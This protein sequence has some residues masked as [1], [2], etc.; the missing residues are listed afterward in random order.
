M[1]HL[2][3]RE[4][5]GLIT[6]TPVVRMALLAVLLSVVSCDGS[7]DLAKTPTPAI[8]PTGASGDECAKPPSLPSPPITTGTR[9]LLTGPS[10]GATAIL[11][12]SEETPCPGHPYAVGSARLTLEPAESQICYEFVIYGL[13]GAEGRDKAVTADVHRG[14][15][16]A[17]G[18]VVVDLLVPF[19]SEPFFP[20]GCR[21]TDSNVI[22]QIAAE[23][24]AFYIEVHSRAYPNGAVRGQL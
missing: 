8:T 5:A 17:S 13:D 24:S 22:S 12:G 14:A 15:R 6:G 16:G 10:G 4:G 3:S 19:D 18:P 11:G 20:T 23:P 7:R 21:P 9:S 2:E 1:Y